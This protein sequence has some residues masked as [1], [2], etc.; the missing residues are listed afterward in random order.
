M[1]EVLYNAPY[2]TDLCWLYPKDADITKVYENRNVSV[3]FYLSLVS[4]V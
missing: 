1:M 3:F 2:G 4:M